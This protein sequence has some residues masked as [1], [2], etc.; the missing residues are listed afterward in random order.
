MHTTIGTPTTEPRP[1]HQGH[2]YR[3]SPEPIDFALTEPPKPVARLRDVAAVAAVVALADLAF[4]RHVDLPY[5][6]DTDIPVLGGLSTAAFLSLTTLLLVAL[7]KAQRWSLRLGF[8]VTGTLV[9]AARSAY[10]PTLLTLVL[11]LVFLGATAVLVRQRDAYLPDVVRSWFLSFGQLPGRVASLVR[12]LARRRDGAPSSFVARVAPVVVPVA[13]LTVFGGIFA[14][15]NPVV[16][17]VAKKIFGSVTLP[18]ALRLFALLVFTTGA[19]MLTKPAFTP[20]RARES[21]PFTTAERA[22]VVTAVSSLATMNMLFFA[23]NGLDAMYLW[24]GSPPP[25]TSTRAYAHA[26][27]AW[28]TVALGLMTVV[29]GWFF[30]GGLAHVKRAR[31]AR[32]LA[33]AWL[34]QG[35]VLAV[36]TFRRM[37]IHVET[38][39]LSDARIFGMTG[40]LF[41][42][43]TLGLVGVKL[44]WKRTFM[45]LLRRSFEA[46]LVLALAFA[47][48][49][50]HR[51]SARVNVARVE[52]DDYQ[53]LVHAME[54]FHEPESVA[55]FLPLLD[56]S[57]V[58]IRRG[59]AA[60][61]LNERD[62]L[63]HEIGKETPRREAAYAPVSALK[64]LEAA[65]G[66]M[67]R[68]LGDV[69]R[70]AAIVPFEYLRNSA[71]EGE[72]ALSEIHKVLPAEPQH[73]LVVKEWITRELTR[74][75]STSAS[76]P[77]FRT[78]EDP[79]HCSAY[80]TFVPAAG[81]S[82][83]TVKLELVRQ[84]YPTYGY[85]S[86]EVH[87]W[88]V[89]QVTTRAANGTWVAVVPK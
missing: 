88:Q 64:E 68:V 60:L 43:V 1:P 34:A 23:Y 80:V 73:E 22:E 42:V 44:A 36:G 32:F 77:E 30:R 89:S 53:A 24:A 35:L 2:P 59:V 76:S 26:G 11:G 10:A 65:R 70:A 12:A 85:D 56:H 4:V 19:V 50:T 66:K 6:T 71:I 48:A 51:L 8:A 69:D 25:G 21:A 55:V 39:G 33:Y 5:S 62:R 14:A 49:P 15:A 16:S 31:N 75:P 63:E 61:L 84:T 9:A 46:G 38:S 20:S 86:H 27:A 81:G 79:S 17:D 40:T 47:V 82:T 52:S 41:V 7:P 28:L 58:R 37:E 45:W 13:L 54:Q 87:T 78:T 29:V 57:D 74:R 67:E 83:E 18:T 3:A 72:I